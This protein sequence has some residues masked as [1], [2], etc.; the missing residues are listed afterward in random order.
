MDETYFKVAG[1]WKYLYR[2][3]DR[4]GHTIA[5]MLRAKRDCAAAR[6][7]LERAIG[8]HDVPEKITMDKSGSN[9]AA[10]LSVQAAS[11]ARIKLRQSRY[12]N[13]VLEQDHRAIKRIVRPMLGFKS[14]R[15][16]RVSITGIELMHTIKR[17]QLDCTEGQV[18]PAASKFYTL[19]F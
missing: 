4:D 3:V 2:E 5:F 11:G 9:T 19:A 16:A 10:I 13:N 6:C 7:F 18:S 8:L 12:L 17:D 1:Q 14:F 15:C